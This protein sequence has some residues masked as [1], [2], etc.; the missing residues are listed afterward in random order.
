MEY[1]SHYFYI[2]IHSIKVKAIYLIELYYIY[3]YKNRVLNLKNNYIENKYAN[4][5]I[6]YRRKEDSSLELYK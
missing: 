3:R 4:I 1:Y 5:N 2:I 6:Y